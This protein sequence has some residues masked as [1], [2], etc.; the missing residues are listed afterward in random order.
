MYKLVMWHM[1]EAVMMVL[2][3][4]IL[5]APVPWQAN[6]NCIMVA[7][8]AMSRHK[9]EIPRILAW[10]C[11]GVTAMVG[12]PVFFHSLPYLSLL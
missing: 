4:Y 9:S 11:L 10:Q 12:A 6:Q 2:C 8:M 5:S 7:A 3:T 1:V